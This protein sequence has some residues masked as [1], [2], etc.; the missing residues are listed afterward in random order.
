MRRV[1]VSL[2]L[3]LCTDLQAQTTQ[4]AIHISTPT[5]QPTDRYAIAKATYAT[6]VQTC[7]DKLHLSDAFKSAATNLETAKANRATATGEDIPAAAQ[8]LM[9]ARSA[10]NTLEQ[11]A[12]T[13]DPAVAAAKHDLD[14]I[15][16]SRGGAQRAE[17]PPLNRSILTYAEKSLGQKIGNGECWTL[18][19]EAVLNAGAQMPDTYVWGRELKPDEP[20]L[21]GDIMQFTT[22]R[23]EGP[24]WWYQMGNPNHTAIVQK[25]ESKTVYWLLWQNPSPVISK[26]IDFQYFKT[27]S[28]KVYR[29]LPQ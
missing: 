29:P 20:I 7:L 5:S 8:A 28:Y 9:Q 22:A 24:G 4:P 13:H 2:L 27:G 10:L 17:L 11:N 1:I 23:F 3:C 6:T 15:T 25:V 26:R 14:A 18:A 12:L 21:P 19:H 16:T